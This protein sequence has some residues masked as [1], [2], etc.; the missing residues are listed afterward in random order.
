MNPILAPDN[1]LLPVYEVTVTLKNKDNLHGYC[2]GYPDLRTCGEWLHMT[3]EMPCKGHLMV[4][5][6]EIAYVIYRP[7]R[8]KE[9]GQ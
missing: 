2:R 7:R 3:V 9:E 4:R 6:E 8:P 5:T 1:C